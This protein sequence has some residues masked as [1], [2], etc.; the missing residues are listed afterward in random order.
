MYWYAQMGPDFAGKSASRGGVSPKTPGS[1]VTVTDPNGARPE[2]QGG[3]KD[4]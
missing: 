1:T 4:E 3:H 2:S